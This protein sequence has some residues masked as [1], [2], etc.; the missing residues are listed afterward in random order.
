MGQA[1]VMW[2]T[3]QSYLF[4]GI[5]FAFPL[6]FVLLFVRNLVVHGL[7][8]SGRLKRDAV[9]R[10]WREAPK[11]GFRVR[12]EGMVEGAPFVLEQ[13]RLLGSRRRRAPFVV[14]MAWP[15]APGCLVVQR[16][17]PEPILRGLGTLSGAMGLLDSPEAEVFDTLRELAVPG[18]GSYVA[19]ASSDTHRDA[20][21]V[22]ALG[23]ELSVL[24]DAASG[25]GV[26]LYAW[27]D[28]LVLLCRE[29]RLLDA[30]LVDTLSRCRRALDESARGDAVARGAR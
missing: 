10:G 20:S 7:A 2:E 27:R 6:L 21:C 25:A 11:D 9:A 8:G 17:V 19:Y 16:R 28:E 18:H 12:Y 1:R 22:E 30:R 24:D 4:L 23:K 13:R 29:P 3:L 14:R 5:C 26:V 15:T